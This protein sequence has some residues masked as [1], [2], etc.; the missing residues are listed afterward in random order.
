[1]EGVKPLAFVTPTIRLV[2][3]LGAGGMGSVWVADH[4]ALRTQVV[5]KFMAA[6]LAASADAIER[7]GREAA[8]AAQVK[9][10]HVVQMLD[11]GVT[12]DGV[13]FI[14]MELL[15]GRDLSK[16]LIE[17][18][19]LS[20]AETADIVGQVAKALGRA[21]ERGIVHRDIKP[22]NIFLCDIGGTE[23][24]VK[25]L[26]FGIAKSSDANALSGGTRTGAM[27]GTPYYMSPEQLMGS[28]LLDPRTDLWA[29]G[30]VVYQCVLGQRPFDAETFGALA[31][32]IHSG[33]L[34]QPSLVDPSLPRAFDDWFARVCARNPDARFTTAREFADSLLAVARSG[35]W[36]PP[37][38]ASL[39][40]T[41]QRFSRS[42]SNRP[43][44]H[45]GMGLPSSPPPPQPS[46]ASVLG[47]SVAA[48]AFVV[49][50]VTG[51][52][53]LARRAT[54]PAT[55]PAA[56]SAPAT[57]LPPAAARPPVPPS[58]A[59]APPSPGSSSVGDTG[60]PLASSAA[61]P[62][63]SVAATRAPAPASSNRRA[64]PALAPTKHDTD[65]F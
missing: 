50:M 29:L 41:T 64:A 35:A 47:L 18:G 36:G 59:P 19:R 39:P 12:P 63:P 48:G 22:E 31:I 46:K 16:H 62:L 24:F 56:S 57:A 13:P 51:G 23:L 60:P 27:V 34:P 25:I 8:A 32:M 28:R 2:R 1:V 9:S 44:T 10:P 43:S 37:V 26:D 14:A 40:Q 65:I 7:F 53:W 49:A 42:D 38:S 5:V 20:L 6:E 55:P 30:V 54:A 15:E 33:E 45:A 3:C 58:A 11:H 21:H 61:R 4:L 17:R 52:M